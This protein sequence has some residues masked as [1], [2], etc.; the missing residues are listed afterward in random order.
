VGVFP[1]GPAEGDVIVQA[2]EVF[3]NVLE[4]VGDGLLEGSVALPLCGPEGTEQGAVLFGILGH[5]ILLAGMDAGS[6]SQSP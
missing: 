5:L 1:I 3:E 6:A 2:S 4:G